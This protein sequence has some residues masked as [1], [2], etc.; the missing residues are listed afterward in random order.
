MPTSGRRLGAVYPTS[1]VWLSNHVAATQDVLAAAAELGCCLA[2]VYVLMRRYRADPRLT[3]LLPRRRGP[4]RGNSR[5]PRE[6]DALID[7][8][9]ETLYLTR[10]KPKISDLVMEVRRR[11]HALG[12]GT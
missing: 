10:Q 1:N 8:V 4:L 11:C 5:L 9:I 12:A 3:S 6:M 7:E 2:H